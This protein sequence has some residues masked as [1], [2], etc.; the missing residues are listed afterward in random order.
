VSVDTSNSTLYFATGNGGSC[1]QPE[2]NGVAVVELNITNLAFIGSWQVP[3]SQMGPD[4][5]FGDTPTVFTATIGA[6]IHLL[7]GVANKNGIYY[8]LD[9]ANISS[10]PVRQQHIANSGQG[11]VGGQGSISPSAWDGTNLYVVS[12]GTQICRQI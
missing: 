5:D 10:G 12:T 4:S 11:P 1:A 3:S 9:E 2:T 8:A 7:V 6:T